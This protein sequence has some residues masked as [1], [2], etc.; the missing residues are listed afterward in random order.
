M[1][2]KTL[3]SILA[4]ILTC[5]AATASDIRRVVTGLDADNKAST[6][7]D[8]RLTLKPGPYGLAAVNLWITDSYPPTP[9]FH[10]ADRHF[11][12]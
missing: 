4:I 3:W 6:L 8:S 10:E 2:R 11:T 5:S 1:L 12:T 9:A 7:F